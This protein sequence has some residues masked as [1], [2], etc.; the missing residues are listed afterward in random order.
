[1]TILGYL[2]LLVVAGFLIGLFVRDEGIAWIIIIITTV[3]WAFIFGPWAIAT[4]FELSLG[5]AIGTTFAGVEFFQSDETIEDVN[6]RFQKGIIYLGGVGA[7]LLTLF[8]SDGGPVERDSSGPSG[9]NVV[10]ETHQVRRATKSAV[11]YRFNIQ[12]Q[13]IYARVRVMNI[14]PVYEPNMLLSEGRYDIAVDASGYVSKRF[15]VDHFG[16][17]TELSVTLKKV[18]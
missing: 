5:Y 15:Y 6:D 16:K 2:I 13:P 17:K 11:Q 7:L 12:T 14:K 3:V 9:S 1:M 18:P 8:D 10:S 4:F